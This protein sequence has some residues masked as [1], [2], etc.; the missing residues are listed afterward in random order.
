MSSEKS[1]A[2]SELLSLHHSLWDMDDE[3]SYF[4]NEYE[5]YKPEHK[6]FSRVL[7]PGK[8]GKKILFITQNLHK[9][10]YGTLEIQ[11]AAKEGKTVR[12][13]WIIDPSE[14]TFTYIGCIKTTDDYTR[15]ERYSSFGTHK[16]YYEQHYTTP[17][18]YN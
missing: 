10:S 2:I 3:V 12:I 13:T 9:S 6:G 4:G 5:V 14:G 17:T 11:R 8:S 1:Y 18:I 15:I 16:M 7:V